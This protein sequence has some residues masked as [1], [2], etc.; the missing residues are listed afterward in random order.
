MTKNLKEKI[1]FSID[2][3]L[4]TKLDSLV[5]GI[6]VKSRSHALD[7]LL[8]KALSE[9]R[10]RKALILAGG[11][12]K[13]AKVALPRPLTEHEDKPALLHTIEWLKK[14][15]VDQVVISIGAHGT[16]I[17]SYFQDG[18]AFGVSIEYVKESEPL[19]T[20]GSLF[21]ARE[22]F[23]STFV[24]LNA[25]MVCSFNLSE[26]ISFHKRA[27]APAT[28]ALTHARDTSHYG[29]VEIEGERISGFVEKPASGQESGSLINAG[30]YV[31]EPGVFSL[32]KEKGM[33]ET[34]VFPQMAKKGLLKG[35]VFSGK[36]VDLEKKGE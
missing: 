30:V 35:Y 6:S 12:K 34:D 16:D 13:S 19:G 26:M 24:A 8:R 14:N 31:F 28:I 9:D 15:G 32:V 23:S 7:I 27:K 5:D 11:E 18:K 20:S 4:L 21:L 17:E 33:L 25:D 36:W 1:A 3:L 29:V 2:P 10:V 22:K